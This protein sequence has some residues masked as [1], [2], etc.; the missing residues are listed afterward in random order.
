MSEK[1]DYSKGIYDARQLGTGRMLILG[2]QH[3]FAMFGATVL[4]PPAHRPER[5]HHS[6]LCRSGHPAV[7]PCHQ[8][9]GQSPYRLRRRLRR[10]HGCARFAGRG[11]QGKP[12]ELPAHARNGSER[13]GRYRLGCC[14]RFPAPAVRQIIKDKIKNPA[15]L[16]SCRTAGI[17]YVQAARFLARRRPRKYKI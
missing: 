17:F 4:V 1:I 5:F 7:P 15:V 14:R 16:F 10:S 11:T 8:G 13:R 3:M 6:A 2:L 9:Q 12:D